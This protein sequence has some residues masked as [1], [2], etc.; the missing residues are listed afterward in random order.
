MDTKIEGMLPMPKLTQDL[1]KLR[2]KLCGDFEQK[3]AAGHSNIS[4]AL[5][6]CIDCLMN[7]R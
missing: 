2:C 7:Y 6:I 1:P 4:Y 3:D 5:G